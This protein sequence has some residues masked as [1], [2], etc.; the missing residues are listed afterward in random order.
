MK[1]KLYIILGV[2]LVLA[3]FAFWLLKF[4][5]NYPSQITLEHP[6]NYFGVTYSKKFA[7][8]LGLSWRQA[9]LAMLDDLQVK[10]VRLPVYWDDLE[11]V[12]GVYDFTDMDYMLKE[13]AARNVKFVLDI[14]ERTPRWPECHAPSW[15]AGK[16]TLDRQAATMVM[17]AKVVERY[18]DH[19]EL[20][21]WQVEN[22][23]LLNVFGECPPA[24]AN[25]LR[26]EVA[27][28]KEL[29]AS[30]QVIISG[31]GEL[32]SWAPEAKIGDIFGATMYRVVYNSWFGYVR[33]PFPAAFY[34]LKA[35]WAGIKPEN[36]IIM[37]L[38]T[39]P[40]V[41]N[42]RMQDLTDKELAK[43]FSMDQFKANVQFAINVNFGKI[44]M[45]GVEWWYLQKQNGHPE[46][47]DFAKTLFK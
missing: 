36:R 42:G 9:Y 2:I 47:W 17:I 27:K 32:S 46:Y 30:R 33:Y 34:R 10:E 18:K 26:S 37:E 12:E 39:E 20:V 11:A 16:S 5:K 40:W 31:S 23:P 19:P 28:V 29:D 22:E 43:S 14:G 13:G 24:D 6:Q 4:S 38:Q 25:F 21:D 1:K 41:A 44:Y 8:L 7:R 3:L 15:V 45:W 35:D